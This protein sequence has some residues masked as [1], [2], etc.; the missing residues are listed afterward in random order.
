ME[1]LAP[2]MEMI[3]NSTVSRA[4]NSL[5]RCTE[6][7]ISELV[8]AWFELFSGKVGTES[9]STNQ[10]EYRKRSPR[11]DTVQCAQ[12]ASEFLGNLQYINSY[13]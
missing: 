11:T 6:L 4:T 3:D 13:S 7:L 12:T 1:T 9:A 2:Y 8:P 5:T 10:S